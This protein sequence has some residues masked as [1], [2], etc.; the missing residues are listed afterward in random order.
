M[1]TGDTEAWIFDFKQMPNP[2]AKRIQL[3]NRKSDEIMFLKVVNV[4]KALAVLY[5]DS[6]EIISLATESVVRTFKFD[7]EA[8]YLN[9]EYV[10]N[11]LVV[12]LK[13]YKGVGILCDEPYRKAVYPLNTTENSL[14]VL[15][16]GMGSLSLMQP[17]N[18]SIFDFLK[19]NGIAFKIADLLMPTDLSRIGF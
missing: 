18:L 5:R 12:L 4:G 2:T 10:S 8:L 9:Y 16:M 1:K 13:N 11:I 15:R 7:S 14:K 3:K 17:K 6:L 19:Y